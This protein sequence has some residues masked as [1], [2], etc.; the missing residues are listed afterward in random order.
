MS[1]LSWCRSDKQYRNSNIHCWQYQ[2]IALKHKMRH[3]VTHP[4]TQASTKDKKSHWCMFCREKCSFCKYL[5][6]YLHS[7][8]KCMKL[9]RWSWSSRNH[10]H[11]WGR[12]WR[13]SSPGK[14]RSRK[15]SIWGCCWWS[16]SSWWG[17]RWGRSCWLKSGRRPS[18]MIRSCSLACSWGHHTAHIVADSGRWC[19]PRHIWTALEIVL[20]RKLGHLGSCSGCTSAPLR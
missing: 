5:W 17:R 1:W 20:L 13:L 11:S 18:R 8:P 15:C 12:K 19:T 7:T 2:Q 10:W 3:I 4:R 6:C 14:G 9:S 16:G